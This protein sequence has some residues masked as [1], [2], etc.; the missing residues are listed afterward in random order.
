MENK[1]QRLQISDKPNYALLIFERVQ[2][3]GDKSALRFKKNGD[4]R[5]ITWR[6]FGQKIN[7]AAGALLEMG[8]AE[9][10]M[11]A[12]F[13]QNRP[14]CTIVDIAALSIRCVPVFIYPTNTAP[15]AEYIVNDCEAR[16]IFVG[17]QEQYDKAAAFFRRADS[18]ERIVAFNSDIRM[19]ADIPSMYFEDFLEIGNRSNKK[20]QIAE[21]LD[22]ASPQ[23]ILTLIYTSGTTGMPKGVILTHANL[24]FS[25]AAHDLRLLDPNEN[26]VSLC[27]L[28]LS[29]IFERAW[30]YYALYRGM[31]N[32][33]LDDPKKIIDVIAEVRPTIM[34][35]VPR[36]YEKIYAGV[37]NKVESAPPMKKKLFDWAVKTGAAYHDRV[38]DELPI[39][40]WL[41]IKYR[42][43]D[44]LVL[45]KIRDVVGGR[46]RFMPCAGAPL[47]PEIESFFYAIGLFV[48]YGYGLSETYATVT[49]HPP[50]HFKFGLVGTPL[51]GV[52]VKIAENGEILVKGGN[53]M[54]GYYKMPEETAAV[55]DD[56]WFRTGD[57]GEFD[58]NGEL[59]ITDR[60]KDLM[61]TSGGKYIA[62]QL[63]ESL[64]GADHFVEQVMII[65]DRRNFVSAL[66]VPS[67][68]VLE[69]YAEN[70]G[71][72]FNSRAELVSRPD[73][74]ELYRKRIE[75]R[76]K[77]L[78]GYERIKEF[79][80]LPSE[81]SVDQNEI[82][83]TMK[84]KRK[85]VVE[86]YA[87]VISG[88]YPADVTGKNR[89]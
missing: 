66:I 80:L 50:R 22:R 87:D 70:H 55:F 77:N 33:Y 37:F 10:Q 86:K 16:V 62:P 24:L 15:Q 67:F 20:S 52:Q 65:G 6:A 36:V 30:T 8:L 25:A 61:K 14:E 75:E 1:E 3:Y 63:I 2:K 49:C 78:A 5:S 54:Q 47:S 71:I 73:I 85:V 69:E 60:I 43:A 11:V 83:P 26:D 46:I 51:P 4:W 31:E 32:Y 59:R 84:I 45:S 48:W 35:A 39:P 68:E 13:S 29:H 76:S 7:A 57:V 74:I 44:R 18:L 27:F 89:N 53:V 81:F 21:R 56:G 40:A 42:A 38:K 19:E 23:D 41:R 28:P 9:T 88:M 34:C 82:T 64:I 17:D 79:T 58:E 12:I 72:T